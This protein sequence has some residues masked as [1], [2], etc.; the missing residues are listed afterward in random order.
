MMYD[1]DNIDGLL[2]VVDFRPTGVVYGVIEPHHVPVGVEHGDAVIAL[3]SAVLDGRVKCD[4]Y[5]HNLLDLSGPN[6]RI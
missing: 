4:P 3:R 6:P 1:D 2:E 5:L